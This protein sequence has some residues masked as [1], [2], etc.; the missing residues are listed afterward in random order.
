M[1]S[2]AIVSVRQLFVTVLYVSQSWLMDSLMT[3]DTKSPI[4][5]ARKSNSWS[6][7]K[8]S[9]YRVKEC[10]PR[11]N[12]NFQSDC[13]E[14]IRSAS[15]EILSTQSINCVVEVVTGYPNSGVASSSRV[16]NSSLATLLSLLLPSKA[17]RRLAGSG[18]P[19]LIETILV[20]L[21]KSWKTLSRARRINPIAP[22]AKPKMIRL[23]WS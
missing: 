9:A 17:W 19:S 21:L 6:A 18:L 15:S 11:S 8:H 3:H 7:L 14:C 23:A 5:S 13:N 20:F 22:A 10:V 16:Q 12:V 1:H 2:I 4:K